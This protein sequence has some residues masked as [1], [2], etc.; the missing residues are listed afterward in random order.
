MQ[1]VLGVW[2]MLIGG[3]V[4]T[5]AWRALGR[6]QRFLGDVSGWPRV[7]ARITSIGQQPWPV[8]FPPHPGSKERMTVVAHYVYAAPGRPEEQRGVGLFENRAGG[9][10]DT[11]TVAVSPTD[12]SLSAPAP[13]SESAVALGRV[14]LIV[15]V[16]AGAA[17]ALLGLLLALRHL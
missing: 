12:P 8:E 2:L 6:L 4:A 3:A 7:P 15:F 13:D 1:V 16:V 9:P 10:G 14:I 17:F 5:F 11:L